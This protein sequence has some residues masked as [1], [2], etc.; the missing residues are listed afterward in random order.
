[1]AATRRTCTISTPAATRLVHARTLL[2]FLR[3]F[4]NGGDA[5]SL[6]VARPPKSVVLFTDM[7]FLALLV[8]V[9]ALVALARR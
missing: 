2:Y 5:K 3:S 8:A 9:L 4:R 6:R 1:M 7:L